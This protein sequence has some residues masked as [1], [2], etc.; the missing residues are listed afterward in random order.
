MQRVL[1]TKGLNW[2]LIFETED[3]W[4]DCPVALGTLTIGEVRHAQKQIA[5]MG[6]DAKFN[7]PFLK[8]CKG[9]KI[10]GMAQGSHGAI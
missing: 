10:A 7:K 3:N 8:R 6:W 1:L 9:C 2:R 4:G 5:K